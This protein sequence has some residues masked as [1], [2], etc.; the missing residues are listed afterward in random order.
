MR[1][2]LSGFRIGTAFSNCLSFTPAGLRSAR[3]FNLNFLFLF[4]LDLLFGVTLLNNRKISLARNFLEK[5][6]RNNFLKKDR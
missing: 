2:G 3:A 5:K 1:S 6:D 4:T